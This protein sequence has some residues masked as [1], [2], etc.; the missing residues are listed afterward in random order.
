M[1]NV[2]NYIGLLKLRLHCVTPCRLHAPC[3]RRSCRRDAH[4]LELGFVRR[5][6]PA[7]ADI[8]VVEEIPEG[9]WAQTGQIRRL[10]EVAAIAQFEH[11]AP[12]A[13]KEMQR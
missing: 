13:Q 8:A 5:G 7:L 1:N 12:I 6:L 4:A 11:L 2:M 10:P 3:R 9:S